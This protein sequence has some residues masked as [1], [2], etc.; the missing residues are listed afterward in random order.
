MFRSW[1]LDPRHRHDVEQA[2]LAA[3]MSSLLGLPVPS[4]SMGML[5]LQYLSVGADVK[6]KLMLSNAEQSCELFKA[7]L[8]IA[9]SSSLLFFPFYKLRLDVVSTRL[10]QVS[11]LIEREKFSDALIQSAKLIRLAQEGIRYYHAYHRYSLFIVLIFS[12]VGWIIVGASFLA[13]SSQIY[14]NR[15]PT[16]KYRVD[17]KL[18]FYILA[19][20]LTIFLLSFAHSSITDYFYYFLPLFIWLYIIEQQLIAKVFSMHDNRHLLIYIFVVLGIGMIAVSFFCRPV[21]SLILIFILVLGLSAHDI[22]CKTKCLWAA[23]IFVAMIFPFIPPVAQVHTNFFLILAAGIASFVSYVLNF[24][25]KYAAICLL[26]LLSVALL[27]LFHNG[28]PN[29]FSLFLPAI[30]WLI[31]LLSW[32]LPFLV[33]PHPPARMWC[34]F[35]VHCAS[36]LLLSVSYDALFFVTFLI[37]LLVWVKYESELGGLSLD[38]TSDFK[39]VSLGKICVYAVIDEKLTYIFFRGP[40]PTF[41]ACS[42]HQ[43]R[44]CVFSFFCIVWRSNNSKHLAF[45]YF[46]ICFHF[47][48]SNFWLI[49]KEF[50]V[51]LQGKHTT[52]VQ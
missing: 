44:F 20:C 22:S 36:Y 6:A 3:L 40:R 12:F 7:K 2:D 28:R 35:T 13:P 10:Q 11:N 51:R 23:A 27:Y 26:P 32:L 52:Q 45:Q 1:G 4:N 15:V 25:K 50:L 18:C 16:E 38:H 46:K 17:K 8:Q 41:S 30:G 31:L 42:A 19:V 33:P 24:S 9:K 29:A 49:F 14:V 37:L 21:L 48:S 47:L 34:L 43:L 39:H 5:P